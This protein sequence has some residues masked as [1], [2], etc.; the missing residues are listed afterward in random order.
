MSLSY[1]VASCLRISIES[2]SRWIFLSEVTFV[3]GQHA[4]VVGENGGSVVE[5]IVVVWR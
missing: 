2:S 4:G 3:S 5:E 1:S